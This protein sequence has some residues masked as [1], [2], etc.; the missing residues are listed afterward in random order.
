MTLKEESLSYS[1]SEEGSCHTLYNHIRKHEGQ[2]VDEKGRGVSTNKSFSMI[3]MG[4]W[5]SGRIDLHV[6][7]VLSDRLCN[8]FRI[9]YP[10]K[11]SLSRVSKTPHCQHIK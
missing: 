9:S 1:S 11:A 5:S 3:F 7:G 4:Q 6:R 10:G 2:S 8:V